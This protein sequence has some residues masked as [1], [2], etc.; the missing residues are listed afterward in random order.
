MKNNTIILDEQTD[1]STDSSIELANSEKIQ[2]PKRTFLK[3]KIG[4]FTEERKEI[5]NKILNIIGITETNRIFYSH[6]LDNN[7]SAQNEILNLLDNIAKYFSIS[8][9]PAYKPD[10][11]MTK[12]Y[13]S[14]IKSVLKD[15]N[16]KFTTMN[17]KIKN[18]KNVRVNTTLYTLI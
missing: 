16:I 15:M 14:I 7:I 6:V 4:R 13:L 12:K 8:M 9:W 2:K 17:S 18:D 10:K 1:E 11:V 5:L 3:N